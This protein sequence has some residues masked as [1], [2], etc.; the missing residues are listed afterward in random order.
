MSALARSGHQANSLFDHLVGAS[1]E[2]W[3]HGNAK[4]LCRPEIDRQL[5]LV[6]RLHR[7]VSRLV[8]FENAVCSRTIEPIAKPMSTLLRDTFYCST[9]Y[10]RHRLGTPLSR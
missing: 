1:D 8:A 6:W 10:K 9:R 7:E 4:R 3:W 5:I 2:H